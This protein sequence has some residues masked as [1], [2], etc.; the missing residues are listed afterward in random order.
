MLFDTIP[1]PT[2]R[3]RQVYL[4]EHLLILY[5][6]NSSSELTDDTKKDTQN[7]GKN[8]I[9]KDPPCDIVQGLITISSVF[10]KQSI[11]FNMFIC[12]NT[13]TR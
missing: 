11:N 10:K 2:L 1:Y 13:P 4:Y 8:D 5:F 6:P 3:F 9:N 7:F 12:G